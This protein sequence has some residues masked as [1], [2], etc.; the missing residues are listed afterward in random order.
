MSLVPREPG[1]LKERPLTIPKVSAFA[2]GTQNENVATLQRSYYKKTANMM[3]ETAF[4]VFVF[5]QILGSER[6]SFLL[7]RVFLSIGGGKYKPRRG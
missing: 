3:V 7:S 5:K 1:S 4:R 2:E 6:M